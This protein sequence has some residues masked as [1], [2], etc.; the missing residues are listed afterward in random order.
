LSLDYARNGPPLDLASATPNRFSEPS[1]WH[2]DTGQAAVDQSN[3][4]APFELAPDEALTIEGRYP[5]CR[6]G[7]IVLWNRHLQ[8]F[9]Y[10]RRRSSLNRRQTRL[11]PDGSFRV[12]VAH[13]D[14]G[15]ENWLDTAGA[16]TGLIF[17]RYLL[18]KEQPMALTT[19]V[20]TRADLS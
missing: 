18:P 14:P 4:V 16:R 13:E 15:T 8:T 17:V 12:V 3:L 2:A 19:R 11:R 6:F 9:E 7:N 5:D 1:V 20:V 10:Q